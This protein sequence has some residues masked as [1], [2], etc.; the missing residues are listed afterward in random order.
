MYK[1]ADQMILDGDSDTNW[2]NSRSRVKV[3]PKASTWK[4]L[5][6]KWTG[7]E[8][9]LETDLVDESKC[10]KTILVKSAASQKPQRHFEKVPW[11]IQH[12][13]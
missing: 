12:N 13:Q 4:Q 6:A 9:D 5:W 1:T 10:N 11:I 7:W 3:S 8:K 2:F